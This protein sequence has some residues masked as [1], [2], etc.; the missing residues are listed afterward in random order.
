MQHEDS[1]SNLFLEALS[2]QGIA[3]FVVLVV[4]LL[5]LVRMTLRMRPAGRE[6][7]TRL[8]RVATL[9]ILAQVVVH[10]SGEPILHGMPLSVMLVYLFAWIALQDPAG[11][12]DPDGSRTR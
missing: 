10:A 2:D 3:G 4:L 6:D 7:S 11:F 5:A 8:L 9:G 12:P 1:A